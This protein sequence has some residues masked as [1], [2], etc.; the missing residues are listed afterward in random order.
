MNI[1]FKV[2]N[3]II[4]RTD[5]EKIVRDSLNYLRAVFTFSEDWHG[6]ITAVF[7]SKSGAFNVILDEKN[8][9]LVPWEVLQDEEFLVSVFCGNL[10][11]ANVVRVLTIKSGY[12][13]G[14]SSRIPTE[15]VFNQIMEKIDGLDAEAIPYDNTESGLEAE[16]VQAAIDEIADGGSVVVPEIT[17][18][19]TVDSTTGTPSVTVSKTGTDEN[20]NFAFEFSG[21]K[22]EN[23]TGAMLSS[24]YD[25]E[26][27]VAEAGGI[28]EYVDKSIKAVEGI[29]PSGVYEPLTLTLSQDKYI[30]LVNGNLFDLNNSAT[31]EIT[32]QEGEKYRIT[33]AYTGNSALYAFY[34][35]NGFISAYPSSA[36]APNTIKT[37]E[38]TI[39][40]G[41][42]ILKACSIYN[43]ITPLFVEKYVESNNLQVVIDGVI[44]NDGHLRIDTKANILDGKKWAAC[45]DSFTVGDFTGYVDPEGHTDTDSDAYD[46]ETGH[47]KTYPWWISQRNNMDVQWLAV[48]GSDF[49]NIE[50]AT[51]PFSSS[52]SSVNYTQ[53]ASDCDY[54]TFMFGLNENS[55][56]TAQIGTKTDTTNETLWGAYNIVLEAVLTAN[57]MV[58]IGIIVSDAF[59]SQT[60]HDAL[61]DI[62]K[63]WG[64]PY[65]DL[66]NGV[67]VPMMIGGR[68]D[69][70]SQTAK[71]LRNAAFQVSQ[72][73][74]H[75]S[76]VGHEYRSTV[77]ENFLR[78]L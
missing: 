67:Q 75:P 45:G 42:T 30:Y 36:G 58:K 17:A 63:Y 50:G 31:A 13:L 25:S 9:C 65:L 33:G 32:V 46:P 19:A 10:I 72:S 53:I 78:S 57:P 16:N 39:P 47:W 70:Y 68:L 76:V 22:G 21:L 14:S 48:G 34:N 27:A 55:L 29:E 12:T 38:I 64:I 61:I 1:T 62:A 51:R 74:F 5:Q 44:S 69:D 54:I 71:A 20:P 23:P 4:V 26:G 11:T 66:R 59:L 40:S 7:Q 52:S 8:T 18:T 56:T 37:V 77:I 28:P 35:S 41:T 6:S 15:D 3:Q 49:T 60:Y 2:T 73:N 43:H 24:I